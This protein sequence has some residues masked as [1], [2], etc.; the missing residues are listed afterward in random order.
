MGYNY[1]L[2]SR[3]SLL[4]KWVK[5]TRFKFGWLKFRLVQPADGA[6]DERVKEE[7]N[8]WALKCHRDNLKKVGHPSLSGLADRCAGGHPPHLGP[9]P[10]HLPAVHP[11]GEPDHRPQQALC[12]GPEGNLPW[13]GTPS[14][15]QVGT[16]QHGDSA[17]ASK[18]QSK[19]A[20]VA[21]TT[22]GSL[23]LR[24]GGMQVCWGDPRPGVRH[25]HRCTRPT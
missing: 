9:P 14:L 7:V 16:R 17:S 10:A 11:P 6:Q 20:K 2:G 18:R 8:P 24:L 3:K 23:G 15:P 5:S 1:G 19:S 12:P 21:T 4:R 25:V 13:P 22:S